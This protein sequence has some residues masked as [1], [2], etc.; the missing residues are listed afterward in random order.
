M[1]IVYFDT[2]SEL[3]INKSK[4]KNHQTVVSASIRIHF[5]CNIRWGNLQVSMLKERLADEI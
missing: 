2:T 4:E 1:K 3:I 5:F